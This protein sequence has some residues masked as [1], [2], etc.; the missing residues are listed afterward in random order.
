MTIK[1]RKDKVAFAVIA[2]TILIFIAVV[3]VIPFVML[4]SGSFT[5]ERYIVNQG[6]GLFPGE[7]SSAAYRSI[8]LN[9]GKV[10]NAY[11]I[12]IFVTVAGTLI[13]LFVT[14]MTAYVLHRRDFRW[15]NRF[16]YFMYFTTIFNGGIT[17]WYIL[18]TQMGFKN[19]VMAL[20]LPSLLNV[21]N[22]M[23]VRNFMAGIPYAITE[24]AK[25]DGANDF[26]IYLKLI[27][28]LSKPVLATMCL[29]IGLAYW[30][31]W[32]HCM[33][34]INNDKLYTL[35]YYL[36]SMINN[37][38]AMKDLMAGADIGLLAGEEL[39]AESTKL[40]MTVVATGPILLL[41][42]FVQKYFVKGVI[43][44]SVKG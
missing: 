35:Q 18:L 42:P 36:Y 27:L 8:F 22:I 2:Y 6:Y 38:T 29:F 41:Y 31:E 21:F 10:L 16:T 1:I 5:S 40:A 37:A 12:T 32:Y 15:R 17:P 39:P 44:G 20:I 43:V 13:S 23:V 33:L 30:N 24:S 26:T 28:P 34:F 9:P 25:I 19:N 4:V 14:T 3:C 11:G 7:F